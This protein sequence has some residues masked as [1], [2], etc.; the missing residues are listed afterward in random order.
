M[1]S[2]KSKIR[3]CYASMM[4]IAVTVSITPVFMTTFS[5]L[6]GRGQ[7]L[8]AEQLGRIPAVLFA[9]FILSIL[10]TGPLA[11]RR[12]AKPFVLAGHL[13]IVAGL[14]LLTAAMSYEMVLLSSCVLGLGAGCLEVVVSPVVAALRPGERAS[15]MNLLHSFYCTGSILTVIIASLSLRWDVSWRFV[16]GLALLLPA[17]L[18]AA[19][20]PVS[21]PPMVHEDHDREPVLSLLKNRHLL[22]SFAIIF[23]AGGIELSTVQWLPT[24]AERVLGFSKSVSGYGLTGF[25]I[26]MAL[27]RILAAHLGH[28][29]AA[30]RLL[31]LGS[32]SCILLLAVGLFAPSPTL[33]LAGCS[34]LG[35]S[36]S[37][38]WPTTLA[39]T[40]DRSPHGG[41]TLF[42]L[43]AVCGNAG[44]FIM[45]WIVGYIA[46]Q[47]SLRQGMMTILACPVT[48]FFLL[49]GIMLRKK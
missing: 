28:R 20:L 7:G 34:C 18:F 1:H 35:F 12:G 47:T 44:C 48:M 36:V 32:F 4:A 22:A 46:D 39:M 10:V 17:A 24:Y 26:G 25:F 27:G 16:C 23:L 9:S 15:A 11:D 30:V 40:A 8:T 19:L 2:S 37:W 31:G 43:L 14:F 42:A 6:F 3:L 49:S 5:A 45:P 38:L 33:A 29:F 13:S 21:L 41:A